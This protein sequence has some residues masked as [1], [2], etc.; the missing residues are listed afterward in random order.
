[1]PWRFLGERRGA[2]IIT[3][4]ASRGSNGFGP[5][6][7]DGRR[8]RQRQAQEEIR[9]AALAEGVK[10]Q[11]AADAA[12]AEE[13]AKWQ[14]EVQAQVARRQEA[15]RQRTILLRGGKAPATLTK[16]KSDEEELKA[17]TTKRHAERDLKDFV[18]IRE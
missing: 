8:R 3:R 10:G 18:E 5:F 6:L 16:P 13:E 12:S 7:N 9:Q 17:I 15:R 11:K 4:W 1:M 2:A 14:A